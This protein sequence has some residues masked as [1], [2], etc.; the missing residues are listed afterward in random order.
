MELDDLL[1]GEGVDDALAWARRRAEQLVDGIE[2]D[3]ELGPLLGGAAP[4]P[5]GARA[6]APSSSPT[7]AA[8]PVRSSESPAPE[9]VAPIPRVPAA[10]DPYDEETGIG[11]AP[12]EELAGAGSADESVP[13][14]E[15]EPPL[16]VDTPAEE[17]AVARSPV[18]DAPAGEDEVD[19][20]TAVMAVP[21]IP[22]EMALPERLPTEP[23]VPVEIHAPESE[24]EPPPEPEPEPPSE[25]E[26]ELDPLAG[27]DFDG[28]PGLEEEDDVSAPLVASAMAEVPL[29]ARPGE[30]LAPT[31]SS[32][33]DGP[34]LTN[35]VMEAPDV[36]QSMQAPDL[37]PVEVTERTANPLLAAPGGTVEIAAV[38]PREGGS[39]LEQDMTL[40]AANPLTPATS[41]AAPTSGGTAQ[42]PAASG[43][44]VEMPVVRT[45]GT[46]EVPIA[47]SGG[48]VEIAAASG[49]G[50]APDGSGASEESPHEDEEDEEIEEIEEFELLDD[51][52]LE[53]VE[54]DDEGP[55]SS[56]EPEWKAALTSAQLGGGQKADETSGLLRPPRGPEEASA[57]EEGSGGEQTGDG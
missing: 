51:D 55:S 24:P 21:A 44:T 6:A 29:G 39:E 56:E 32:A 49:D 57:S 40:R 9:D 11:A 46:A 26:P 1:D 18:A 35:P 10:L 14:Q 41:E 45:G 28:L 53:L 30:S 37:P 23:G 7:P 2:G 15:A 52:D 22:S 17:P 3:P 13:I 33:D 47:T 54:E 25:P 50:P 34:D 5:E 48:T 31:S 42:M 12:R 20:D 8:I 27:I 43:G 38:G 19:A 16:A 4:R 36:T